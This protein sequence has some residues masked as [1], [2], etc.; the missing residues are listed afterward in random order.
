M[1][2]SIGAQALADATGAELGNATRLLAVATLRVQD[3]APDAPTALQDEAV[4]RFA[5]Y[6]D[7]SSATFGAVTS[8]AVGPLT[9]SYPVNHAAAFRNSGA[10]ALL[11]RYRVRRGGKV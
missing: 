6:L 2:V 9:A 4:I 11:T 10:A 3:Y 5:G 7:T 1:A 8:S